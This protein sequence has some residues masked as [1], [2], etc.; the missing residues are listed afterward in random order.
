MFCYSID[1]IIMCCCNFCPENVKVDITNRL[2]I[3]T[4]TKHVVEQS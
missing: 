3:M 2:L 4:I 1:N